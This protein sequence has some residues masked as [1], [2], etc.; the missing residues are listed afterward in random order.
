MTDQ[1][2]DQ[3]TGKTQSPAPTTDD[4]KGT[5][6]ESTDA[7]RDAR[8]EKSEKQADIA[9]TGLATMGRNLARNLARHGHTVAVHNR[10][11]ART[12]SLIAEH[13]DEGD[14]VPAETLADLV[15]V[16]K[17]P[18]TVIVMVKAGASTDTVIDELA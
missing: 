8:S 15:A 18:R 2:T 12:D 9:V 10:T 13:G 4:G 11:K 3:E 6:E 14:F 1:T 16:L 17:K 5:P 7:A